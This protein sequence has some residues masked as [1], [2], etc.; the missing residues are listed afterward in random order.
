MIKGLTIEN[1]EKIEAMQRSK[2]GRSK[3]AVVLFRNG[4][5]KRVFNW[6]IDEIAAFA[7]ENGRTVYDR[8]Y[9][10]KWGGGR[11]VTMEAAAIEQT[12]VVIE[13]EALPVADGWQPLRDAL[14]TCEGHR[15]TLN[16]GRVPSGKWMDIDW[17]INSLEAKLE[18]V[19]SFA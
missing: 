12:A 13:P 17:M 8:Y 2:D 4:K 15:V 14:K 11:W 6:Q 3:T 9:V 18:G 16:V 10:G 19:R 5:R 7:S 1:L